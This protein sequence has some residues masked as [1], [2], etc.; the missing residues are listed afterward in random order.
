MAGP[1]KNLQQYADP[2]D[3]LNTNQVTAAV[4]AALLVGANSNR[5]RLTITN[6]GAVAVQVGPSSVT[7]ANGHTIPAGASIVVYSY[8]AFYVIAASGSP[9]V[10]FLEE[11]V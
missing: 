11:A 9:V 5:K 1:S 6:T 10:T 4:A 8:A 7:A 3:T 2:G